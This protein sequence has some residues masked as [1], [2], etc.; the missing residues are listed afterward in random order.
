MTRKSAQIFDLDGTAIDSPVHQLPSQRLI[1]AIAH[2]QDKYYFCAATGRSWSY[3]QEVLQALNLTDPC[4]ITAGTQICNPQTGEIIWQK[5]IEPSDV[6]QVLDIFKQYPDLYMLRNDYSLSDYA[7]K[8]YQVKSFIPPEEIFFLE[9]VDVEAGL[10]DEISQKLTQISG[11]AC[12]VLIAQDDNRNRDIHVLNKDATKEQAV[13]KLLEIIGISKDNATGI[14][15]GGNDLHLFN[16]VGTKVAMGNASDA[17]KARADI[18]IDSINNDGL[19][20]YFE[21]LN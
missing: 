16:A 7:E 11:I 8:K 12:L 3:G 18:V 17:L 19:A 10:A 14:G 21:S 1:N 15:D 9:L 20:Q 4:V 6:L 13:A 2:H 5:N